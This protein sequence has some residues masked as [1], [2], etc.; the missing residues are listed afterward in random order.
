M[1]PTGYIMPAG[2]AGGPLPG[3]LYAQQWSGMP[4]PVGAVGLLGVAGVMPYVAIATPTVQAFPLI[5]H[6]PENAVCTNS[7]R[8]M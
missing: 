5:L 8:T 7:N 6:N 4:S 1:F 2:H 3:P